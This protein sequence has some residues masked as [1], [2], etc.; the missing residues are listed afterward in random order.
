MT[1]LRWKGP[2]GTYLFPYTLKSQYFNL[3]INNYGKIWI[4]WINLM[5]SVPVFDTKKKKKKKKLWSSDVVLSTTKPSHC[6][7]MLRIIWGASWQNQQ[8]DL[9]AQRI[10]RS[11]WA[12]AQIILLVWSWGDSSPVGTR[13]FNCSECTKIWKTSVIHLRF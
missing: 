11:A 2:T 9:C 12:S 10:L 13:R 8:N 7:K 4:D 3:D 6:R 5:I 1:W